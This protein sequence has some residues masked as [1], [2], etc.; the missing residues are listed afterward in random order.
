MQEDIAYIHSPHQYKFAHAAVT[1]PLC[2]FCFRLIKHLSKYFS[3][4]CGGFK[5]LQ[6]SL[7]RA[8]LSHW[9]TGAVADA[10]RKM[11]MEHSRVR[12]KR[13]RNRLH[14]RANEHT[15]QKRPVVDDCPSGRH[16]PYKPR[17]TER[18]RCAIDA[19]ML[20]R[21]GLRRSHGHNDNAMAV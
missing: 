7:T 13:Y 11:H 14:L 5:K 1:S 19:R 12:H 16:L 18:G 21:V 15:T 17:E 6:T 2:S 20:E 3:S 8:C 9:T 10:R 4:S